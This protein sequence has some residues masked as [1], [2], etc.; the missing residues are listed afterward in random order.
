MRAKDLAV[1]DRVWIVLPYEQGRGW[2]TI[3]KLVHM[4]ARVTFD[5]DYSYIFQWRDREVTLRQILK[6]EN[7]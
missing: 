2:A 1:G 4:G 7:S 5:Q 3:N 6:K